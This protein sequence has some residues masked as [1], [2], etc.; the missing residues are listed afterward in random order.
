MQNLDFTMIHIPGKENVTHYMWRHR[1]PET[2]KNGVEK[3]VKGVAALDH[4]VVLENI[5]AASAID[6]ELKHL[7]QA[8]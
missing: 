2:A 4:A 8:I 5:A 3:H 7:R 6:P 1:L